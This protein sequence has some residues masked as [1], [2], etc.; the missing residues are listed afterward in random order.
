MERQRYSHIRKIRKSKYLLGWEDDSY[1]DI[2]VVDDAGGRHFG[3]LYL[4]DV[5]FSLE[6]LLVAHSASVNALTVVTQKSFVSL[7]IQ[8]AACLNLVDFHAAS[9][10]AQLDFDSYL[11]LAPARIQLLVP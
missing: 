6:V 9:S 8:D 7:G 4:P 5:E 2:L 3:T 11:Y 1:S 10:I